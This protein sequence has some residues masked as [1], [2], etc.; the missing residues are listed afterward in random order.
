MEFD[1]LVVSFLVDEVVGG[2]FISVPPGH[3][4]CVYD[5]GRGVLPHVWGPGL[6]LKIPFWQIAKMF[7]AQI[8]EY[9]IRR[10]FDIS[11]N[12]EALGD[13]PVFTTSKDGHEL[14]IEASVLFR[15]DKRNAPELWENIGENVVSKVVRPTSRSRIAAVFA[16]LTT[17]EIKA[18][19]T[20]IESALK[21]EINSYFHDKGL[22]CEGILLSQVRIVDTDNRQ[23]ALL[24]ADAP[25]IEMTQPVTLH[26]S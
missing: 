16:S 1:R 26:Q 20:S 10:G 23:K 13:E 22:N 7:N 5:R 19:R 2:F 9:T 12:K 25:K 24:Q 11:Q 6:H 17:D 14:E 15:I 3:I 4:A 8:L 21:E 18:N